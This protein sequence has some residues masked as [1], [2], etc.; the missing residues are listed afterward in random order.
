MQ[1]RAEP[2]AQ[3]FFQTSFATNG[4]DMPEFVR[5]RV[6]PC[7]GIA[8]QKLLAALALVQPISVGFASTDSKRPVPF[9]PT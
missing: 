1:S 7:F 4:N 2:A 9:V 8:R 5:K 6:G 3:S